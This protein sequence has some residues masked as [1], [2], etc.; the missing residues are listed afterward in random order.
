M[1]PKTNREVVEQYVKALIARDLDLQA[2][3]C[4]RD[5]VVDYPQSGERIRGTIFARPM[6]AI[7]AVFR[8][9]PRP[10]LSAARTNGC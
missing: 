10:R 4:N 8:R 7:R 1:T 5:M 3:V 9:V 6:R 2:E